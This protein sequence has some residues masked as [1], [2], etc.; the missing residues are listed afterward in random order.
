METKEYPLNEKQRNTKKLLV[1]QLNQN[2]IIITWLKKYNLS[3]EIVERDSQ[4]FFRYLNDY[5]KCLKCKAINEC[6]MEPIG[7]Q[8][9]L[10][11]DSTLQT[12]LKPCRYSHNTSTAHKEYFLHSDLPDSFLTNKLT[13]SFTIDNGNIKSVISKITVNLK[14]EDWRGIYLYGAMGVGK[15]LMMSSIANHYTRNKKTVAFHN[16]ATLNNLAKA[17]INDFRY[18]DLLDNMKNCEVLIMDDI[19]SSKVSEWIRD[20]WLYDVLN[21]RLDNKA[22]TFISG[23]TDYE[24]LRKYFTAKESDELK[25]IRLVE[26]IEGLTI[27]L[28][29]EGENLRRKGNGK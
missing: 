6:Q 25:A 14:D 20:D 10:T 26:R 11:Y 2:K 19:G 24:G 18:S 7:Y 4:K 13:E 17:S 1:N 27:P 9:I 16:M 3:K 5:D 28:E 12:L 23:N 22:K 8:R 29:L 21:T 15:T